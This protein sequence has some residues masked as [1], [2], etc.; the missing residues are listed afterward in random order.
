MQHTGPETLSDR[1]DAIRERIL[2]A[3]Q[4]AGRSPDSVTLIGV[5]KTFP[6]EDILEAREAGLRHFGENKVQELVSK[7]AQLP[8]HVEGGDVYWHMI[9]HL[10]RNKAKEVVRRADLFHGLD[11]L[12][13][14]EELDK[15]A[16]QV[17]RVL[18]CLVQVNVSGEESKSG[19][20]P[21]KTY[22]LLRELAAFQHIQV[23]GLMTIAEPVDDPEKVRPQFRLLRTL[24]EGY[25]PES[26]AGDTW[27]YL[28]MG[29]SSD[30]EVAIEEGATHVR[31]GSAI[32]GSRSYP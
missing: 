29:M 27:A 15:R 9:G 26:G 21:G 22:D 13:L 2:R 10:Q 20:E 11:S 1:L 30:F 25:T 23:R 3:C 32:F 5:T 19:V 17:G 31:I 24:F 28:S 6:I 12:R 8:G 4:R 18:P 7:A 16:A 14:A